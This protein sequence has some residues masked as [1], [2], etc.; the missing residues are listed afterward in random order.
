MGNYF[1]KMIRNF[2][3]PLFIAYLVL[4]LFGLVMI[5]SASMVWAVNRI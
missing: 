4:C 3:Y 5:Y 1:K 2:D